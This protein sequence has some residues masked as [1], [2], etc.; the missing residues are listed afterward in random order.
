MQIRKSIK[1]EGARTAP[2][3]SVLSA[4][5]T[6]AFGALVVVDDYSMRWDTMFITVPKAG[7]DLVFAGSNCRVYEDPVY[8]SM[9]VQ[10][11]GKSNEDKDYFVSTPRSLGAPLSVCHNPVRLERRRGKEDEARTTSGG[12]TTRVETHSHRREVLR[13]WLSIGPMVR[14]LCQTPVRISP[15]D[16]MGHRFRAE[17]RASWPSLPSCPD[18]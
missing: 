16:Y 10:L 8:P 11:Y 18:V 9:S 6:T 17:G 1:V 12:A 14:T 5:L 4:G 7:C 2:S 15:K 3:A 13:P